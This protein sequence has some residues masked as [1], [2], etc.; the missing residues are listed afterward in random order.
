MSNTRYSIVSLLNESNL[1]LLGAN[2]LLNFDENIYVSENNIFITREYTDKKEED[3]YRHTKNVSDIA[4]IGYTENKLEQKGIITVDGIVKNQYSMDEKDG[5]LRLVTTSRTSVIK[6]NKS[7]SF[8]TSD[9][10]SSGNNTVVS[11]YVFN[12][13]DNSLTAKVYDFAPEG[14]TAESVRFDGDTAYV[15]TA[16][17]VLNTDPVYFFDLSD[18]SN[19]TYTDTG[20][21]DGY[22]TSLIDIGNGFLLGIGVEDSYNKVSIYEET[23]T[24]V[25]EVDRFIFTG[26]YSNEYKSYYIDRERGLFGF[27]VTNMRTPTNRWDTLTGFILLHFNGYDLE[28]VARI[29][30]ADNTS[31]NRN[32]AV[33]YNGYFY[34]TGDKSFKPYNFDYIN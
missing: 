26:S 3:G 12:L 29:E 19:I 15:C 5:Y 14:E 13:S 21:I 4:V 31:F 24:K 20:E 11:L 16:I 18:Y 17:V 34:I 1:E 6:I 30:F 33:Y 23:L 8:T 7:G 32:R 10:V 25:E 2:A 28:E 22:S 27:F 9:A